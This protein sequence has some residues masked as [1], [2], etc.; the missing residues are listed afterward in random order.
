MKHV[1]QKSASTSYLMSKAKDKTI[2]YVP[3]TIDASGAPSIPSEQMLVSL[4]RSNT[5]VWTCNQ[6]FSVWFADRLVPAVSSSKHK[7]G[8]KNAVEISAKKL[9]YTGIDYEYTIDTNGGQL[10]PKVIVNN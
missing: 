4:N 6:S 3:I 7:N 10:D 9:P 2:I 1:S 8:F 5:I